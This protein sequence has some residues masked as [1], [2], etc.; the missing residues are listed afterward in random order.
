MI[1]IKLTM[2]KQKKIK[3]WAVINKDGKIR[4]G[5]YTEQHIYQIYDKERIS[6]RFLNTDKIVKVEIKLL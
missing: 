2:K 6:D 1:G 4:K 3:A 5:C